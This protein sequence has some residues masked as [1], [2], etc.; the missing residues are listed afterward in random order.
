[1][2]TGLA[3]VVVA[4]LVAGC[5]ASDPAS[6]GGAAPAPSQGPFAIAEPEPIVFV[7]SDGVELVGTAWRPEGLE[8]APVILNAGPYGSM[9]PV[10]GAP[11]P[12]PCAPA[13]TDPFWLDEYNGLPRV[14]VESGFAWVELNVR[15]TGPSGGC[16]GLIGPREREDLV[17]VVDEL[18][19]AP[20]STGSVG[21][22]G[23]SYMGTTALATVGERHPALKAVIAGGITTNEYYTAY[24]PQGAG[25]NSAGLAFAAPWFASVMVIPPLGGGP[26][27]APRVASAYPG[28]AC[29][30]FAESLAAGATSSAT[31]ERPEAYFL[32]RRHLERLEDLDAGVLVLEGFLDHAVGIQVEPLWDLLGST[33]RAFVLGEWDH[34]FPDDDLLAGSGLAWDEL[35]VAWFDHFLRDGPAPEVLGE[36]RYQIV[37]GDW[38]VADRWPALA[39]EALYVGTALTPAPASGDL[40]YRMAPQGAPC[41]PAPADAWAVALTE[42]LAAPATLAGNP[43]A[44]FEVEVDEPAATIAIEIWDVPEGD[45]C[46]GTILSAG[47]AD[48]RYRDDPFRAADVPTGA[49]LGVRVDFLA[50][51]WT[52]PEGHRLGL[53][54]SA[55]GALGVWSRESTATVTVRAGAS[56]LLLPTGA[57]VGGPAPAVEYPPML[58]G[59]GWEPTR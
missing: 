7:A 16:F 30:E 38:S 58:L 15:G 52:V 18:S 56:H 45:V 41:G 46:A 39:S 8:K 33:P 54:M 42:P 32:D 47:A 35:G 10:P 44:W 19:R 25:G 55:S 24:T 3:G 27:S 12:T 29:P 9:C 37:G 6:D 2:R 4:A 43:M 14:L 23:L 1:M 40:S 59:P 21:M 28:R 5:F 34:R 36:V 49:P 26:D 53:T 17:G 11:Y 22:M 31:E 50:T 57:G 20:W 51:S 13:T 48:L